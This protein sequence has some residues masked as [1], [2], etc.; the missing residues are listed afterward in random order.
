MG[1]FKNSFKFIKKDVQLLSSSN[2]K[3]CQKLNTYIKD[4]N[5][6]DYEH[7]NIAKNI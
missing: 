1:F 7:R 4:A 6:D 5:T 3:D 2:S